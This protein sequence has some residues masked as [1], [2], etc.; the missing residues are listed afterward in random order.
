MKRM[1]KQEI[2]FPQSFLY[3]RYVAHKQGDE[4]RFSVLNVSGIQF[5]EAKASGGMDGLGEDMGGGAYLAPVSGRRKFGP[6]IWSP[7]NQRDPPW[8][9]RRSS[10]SLSLT[11]N[12]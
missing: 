11:P 3:F 7:R 5:S 2:E 12:S 8:A 10:W 9:D 4:L 1:K 6:F